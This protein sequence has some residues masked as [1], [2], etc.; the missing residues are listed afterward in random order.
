M[1]Y[2]ANYGTAVSQAAI[3]A[4]N[5]FVALADTPAGEHLAKVAGAFAN[6]PDTGGGGGSPGGSSGQVQ[7]NNGGAFGG[8]TG[9]T[10]NGTDTT[11][12][13]NTLFVADNTDATKL[14]RFDASGISAA[15]TRTL[16]VPNATDTLA[17]L[18]LAQTFSNKTLGNT[19]VITVRDDRFTLQDDGDATKQVVFSLAGISA[20]T[21][22][23]LTVPDANGTM[24]LLGN[25]S[26]G[27]GSI[28]LATSPTLVTPNLGTP[29]AVTLTNAT[30][31]P[32]STGL[33]GLGTG[34]ATALAVNV[35]S[36][37]AFITFNGAAGTP[38]SITL[39]NATG[40]PISGITGL[41]SGVATWLATPSSANLAS[42]VTDETGS[43][44][45]VFATSPTLTT[46]TIN[47]AALNGDMQ[48]DGTPNTDDTW[49]GRSTNTFNAGATIAQFEAV[50]MDSSS[51]WQL[52]DADAI[53]TAGSV[54]IALAAESGTSTNP[55]RV[56]LPGTFVRNDA[57]NWTIGG[58]IYLSTTPGALTQ[59]A[60]SGTDDVVRICGRAVTADVIWWNPSENWATVV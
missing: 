9:Q 14:F 38:S 45:L 10:T 2:I 26:T 60:P 11:F 36:A 50:Y 27:S 19:N 41:G 22:R 46:P 33:T 49:N 5:S 32:I 43:G 51:T 6:T 39:T 15:T 53:T 56:I 35:G 18:S 8:I 3:N 59:T 17:V 40:L 48:V 31:L 30:G 58:T 25:T 12:A 4:I 13:A 24:T 55:L 47:G 16:T 37:G 29:S 1:L 7:Y 54:V 34:V 20:A 57:W 44:P 42:A 21:T 23:T 52:T 28:V